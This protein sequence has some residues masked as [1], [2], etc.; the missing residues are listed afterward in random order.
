MHACHRTVCDSKSTENNNSNSCAHG[1]HGGLVIDESSE[2]TDVGSCASRGWQSLCIASFKIRNVVMLH[3][4]ST[5]VKSR[6]II[7]IAWLCLCLYVAFM[8]ASQISADGLRSFHSC[9]NSRI[10]FSWLFSIFGF[11]RVDLGVLIGMV[12]VALSFYCMDRALR[13]YLVLVSNVH[14]D[15]DPHKS[16]LFFRTIGVGLVV[17]DSASFYW[18]LLR[19]SGWDPPSSVVGIAIL[20]AL[21]VCLM[22]VMAYINI[23][24][25]LN[26]ERV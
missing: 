18:G 20:T 11:R 8:I 3:T 17:L 9:F 24:L 6:K 13:D 15:I 25:W 1:F 19:P 2:G 10:H 5:S 12:L 26:T 4:N 23:L 16:R 21:Y 22:A 14:H 7:A